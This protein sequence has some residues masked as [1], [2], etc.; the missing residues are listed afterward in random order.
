MGDNEFLRGFIQIDLDES[1]AVPGRTLRQYSA[2][3]Q[4][5]LGLL[6]KPSAAPAA[7]ETP[8]DA[9]CRLPLREVVT[10]GGASALDRDAQ[11]WPAH[12]EPEAEL[13]ALGVARQGA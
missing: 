2:K 9:N 3:P 6:F 4:R 11:P 5:V 8:A 10:A 7:A 1:M 13:D 12:A